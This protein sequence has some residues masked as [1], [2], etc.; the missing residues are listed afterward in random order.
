M[1]EVIS[2]AGILCAR[3]RGVRLD[4]TGIR[5]RRKL[6]QDPMVIAWNEISAAGL[7]KWQAG[8]WA[9]GHP[10]LRVDFARDGR[11]LCAGF[12]LSRDWEKMVQ[13]G[14]HIAERAAQADANAAPSRLAP[15]GALP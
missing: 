14:S 3:Q 7:G 6:T 11:A 5:F 2:Q 15:S 12:L 9:M 1:V 10:L 8:R 4:T 13:L